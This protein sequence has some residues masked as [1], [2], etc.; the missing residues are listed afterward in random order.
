[1]SRAQI[2]VLEES[3]QVSLGDLLKSL[4]GAALEPEI[5]PELLSD[6]FHHPLERKLPDQKLRALLVFPNLPQSHGSRPEPVH[7]WL[8]HSSCRRSR[9]GSGTGLQ[10]LSW[11][12][13]SNWLPRG[14]LLASHGLCLFLEK[15]RETE[16]F[17]GDCLGLAL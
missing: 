9:L 13:S 3:N 6:L 5:G 17:M 16:M 15:A 1:M 14:L 2:G 11:G 10:R 7:A 8:F 12:L 4:N